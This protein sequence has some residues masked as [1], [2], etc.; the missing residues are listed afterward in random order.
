MNIH[1]H[2]IS[3]GL[4]D[5]LKDT[6]VAFVCDIIDHKDMTEEM[7]IS[8]ASVCERSNQKDLY[9]LRSILVSAGWNKNDD[10]FDV[11]DL[12]A[13][14]DT[15][16]DKPFNYMHNDTDIIG[17]MISSTAM[18][19]DG[20]EV[21]EEPLPEKMDL[22]TSAVIYKVWS[23]PDQK[24]RV[25]DL[26]E[27]IDSNQLA[28]SMECVFNNFDYAL[29][30]PDGEQKVIS[31]NEDSAF[32]T[33]HLRAYGG[34]GEFQGYKIGR[35]LR[36]LYFTGKGLVDRPANPRSV[37]LPK[38]DP[39]GPVQSNMVLTAMEV[40]MPDP[41]IL[42]EL[43]QAKASV[44]SLSSE[45]ETYKS[46]IASLTEKISTLENTVASINEEKLTLSQE[47]Q[48]LVSEMKSVSRKSALMNA[49]AD[50]ARASE[51]VVKF[52][53]ATD[54]MFESVVALIVPAPAPAPKP[55]VEETV[56]ADETVLDTVEDVEPT[57]TDIDDTVVD[58]ISTAS[59]W[60]SNHILKST[61]QKENK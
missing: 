2:E 28:V 16:V 1:E 50:E 36:N 34:A 54:E 47:L 23:D 45:N 14:K 61:S 27:Q 4:E 22:V 60:I 42:E 13:A 24:A 46:T 8:I 21:T 10:V 41:Q 31:R 26:I 44:V 43:E 52:S 40:S 12:F 3:D 5:K 25:A 33:K 9:Y 59:D 53:D 56:E 17:H 48:K 19:E 15:P 29:I 57:V 35:L 7:N 38:S 6:S 18:S 37:I 51:L 20:T 58:K 32:L 30:G 55:E 39:F 11:A 49:G